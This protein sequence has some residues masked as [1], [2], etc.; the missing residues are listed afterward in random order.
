MENFLT[1]L[2]IVLGILIFLIIAV[3]LL[4]FFDFSVILSTEGKK[5]KVFI[6]V[7]GIKFSVPLSKKEKKNVEKFAEESAEA[8]EETVMKRFFD[9]RNNFSRQ[10]KALELALIY[11]KKRIIIDEL[12]AVGEF[13]TGSAASS[14]IAYGTVMGF[15]NGVFG[16]LG[17][18]F[19]LKKPPDIRLGINYDK[20]VFDIRFMFMVRTK[21]WYLLRAF[22]IYRNNIKV[23][24]NEL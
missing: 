14:G 20:P 22:L 19:S 7:L 24:R 3:L 9:M 12:G 5:I 21:P 11:M 10:K 17:Q 4:L 13:G 6:K 23:R 1:V 16:F 18:Y 15:V 8:E 2:Y